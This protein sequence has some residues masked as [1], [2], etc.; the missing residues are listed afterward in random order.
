MVDG[1]VARNARGP[2]T[3]ARSV[4]SKPPQATC[5]LQPRLGRD[6]LGVIPDQAAETADQGRVHASVDGG[7]GRLVPFL[8]PHDCLTELFVVRLRTTAAPCLTHSFL[9]V[10]PA[11]HTTA[12]PAPHG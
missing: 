12:S 10:T 7:E 5:D 1:P 11:Q 6:I 4:A 8:C 3:K 2:G 9:F